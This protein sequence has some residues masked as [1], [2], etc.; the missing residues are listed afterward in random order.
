MLTHAQRLA[1]EEEGLALRAWREGL[2][3]S[4]GDLGAK[5]GVGESAVQQWENGLAR[6]P[7]ARREALRA[8]GY[9]AEVAA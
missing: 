6:I 1:R 2:K 7:A 4:R 3:L 9:G 5:L 8:L